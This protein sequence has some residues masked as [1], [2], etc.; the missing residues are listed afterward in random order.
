MVNALFLEWGQYLA[1]L[2]GISPTNAVYLMSF[3]VCVFLGI[4]AGVS[5]KNKALGFGTFVGM[6]FV[7]AIL[8]A[9]PLWILAM[10]SIIG[11]SMYYYLAGRE[12]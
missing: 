8:D 9:F 5:S 10:A 12:E 6:L 11:G 3:L 4:V 2:F 1:S 7:F